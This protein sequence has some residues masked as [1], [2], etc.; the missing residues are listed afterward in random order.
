MS[1][2]S[3]PRLLNMQPPLAQDRGARE[4]AQAAAER[5]V[6]ALAPSDVP[7][8]VPLLLEAMAPARS[9]QSKSGTCRLIGRLSGRL[10]AEVGGQLTDIVQALSQCMVDAHEKVKVRAPVHA[11]FSIDGPLP[12]PG[13]GQTLKLKHCVVAPVGHLYRSTC[14]LLLAG[15]TASGMLRGAGSSEQGVVRRTCSKKVEPRK[16]LAHGQGHALDFLLQPQEAAWLARR[17]RCCCCPC[18]FQE[19]CCDTDCPGGVRQVAAR[20]AMLRACEVVGNRDLEPFIPGLVSCIVKVAET[21]DIVHRMSATTFVQAIEAPALAIMV[22]FL[23]RGA[24][25]PSPNPNTIPD[26]E[27]TLAV[28]ECCSRHALLFHAYPG[29]L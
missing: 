25:P 22:P 6:D 1:P 19:L 14:R 16:G 24:A 3:R 23:V 21:P 4:A 17:R 26:S 28:A 18:L 15:F 2:C 5:L 12:C 20:A 9:W 10:P 13:Q 8:A 11:F 27:L 29:K 7:L